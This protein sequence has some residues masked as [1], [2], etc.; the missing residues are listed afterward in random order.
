[1][2]GLLPLLVLDA[3]RGGPSYGYAIGA[4]LASHGFGAIKGSSLYPLLARQQA[5]G[6]VETEWRPGD[7]DPHRKYFLLT[8]DGEAE[9]IRLRDGWRRFVKTTERFIS[10]DRRIR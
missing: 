10:N 1:M 7:S 2:R 3:L 8:A 5:C 6:F 4:E 9:A